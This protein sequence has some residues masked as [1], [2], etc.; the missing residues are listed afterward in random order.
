MVHAMTLVPMRRANGPHQYEVDCWMDRPI[1]DVVMGCL[2]G[3][4]GQSIALSSRGL[5]TCYGDIT[6]ED[7]FAAVA[8]EF[9]AQHAAEV[10]LR[11][12]PEA[13]GLA[14]DRLARCG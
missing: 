4:R 3:W 8:Q 11:G 13:V 5:A 10:L 6:D 9:D 14:A 2:C 7:A 12:L 1:D